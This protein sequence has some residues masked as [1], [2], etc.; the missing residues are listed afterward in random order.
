M[1]QRQKTEQIVI[2]Y[3]GL[4][5][6]TLHTIKK[7]H[8][9]QPPNGNGW[10][11]IGYHFVIEGPY[12][13]YSDYHHARGNMESDGVVKP[14][15]KLSLIGSHCEGINW[16]TIGIC[17]V[18]NGSTLTQRQKLKAALLSRLLLHKM[19][20]NYSLYVKGIVSGNPKRQYVIGHKETRSGKIH[21][22]ICPGYGTY[23]EDVRNIYRMDPLFAH[24]LSDI[25]KIESWDR[26]QGYLV[27]FLNWY[28]VV[29]REFEK[30]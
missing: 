30:I 10:E 23:K 22:K 11:D 18:G 12:K 29:E 16:R 7:W 19:G 5:W 13:T 2:H 20:V 9:S 8:T 24:V 1:R 25:D 17:L 28:E 14:G 21:K 6:G 26:L 4:G 15:R 27:S 3:S